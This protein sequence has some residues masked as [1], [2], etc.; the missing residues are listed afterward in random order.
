MVSA[1]PGQA[2]KTAGKRRIALLLTGL[3]DEYEWSVRAGVQSAVSERGATLMSVVGSAL[4]DPDPM[5]RARSFVFDLL[6]ANSVDALLLLGSTVGRYVGPAAMG[7]WLERYPLPACSIGPTDHVASVQVENAE[8]VAAAVRHLIVEH[9]YR[10]IA[11]V[12][13]P[14]KSA[15]A[16]A[17]YE[18]YRSVLRDNQLSEDPRLVLDGDFTV[19]GGVRAVRRLFDEHQVGAAEVDAIV[20]ANDN[21]AVG[22]IEELV[23][24]GVTVPDRVAVVGFDD[25]TSSRTMHPA[26]TTVRQPTEKLGREGVRSL[27]S[28]LEGEPSR[29]SPPLP[30]ELV[31]RRSCGCMPTEAPPA[32][33]GLPPELEQLARRTYAARKGGWDQSLL[34]SLLRDARGKTGDIER[35]LE[36]LLQR[37]LH[38]GV[39]L[40]PLQDLLTALR[41]QAL[42]STFHDPPLQAKIED[43]VHA[44]RVLV[45]RLQSHGAKE[46]A[47]SDFA[48]VGALSQAL[49]ARMFGTP[50]MVSSAL[51]E[52]L[53]GLGFDE[54][55]VSE[56]IPG[57]SPAQLQVAFGFHA[58]DL[59]P[60]AERYPGSLVVPPEFVRLR[61]QS[62]VLMPLTYGT[63]ALGIAILP[64]RPVDRRIYELLRPVLATT[65]KG[66]QLAR[67][68]TRG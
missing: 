12:R 64:A 55:V 35:T 59:Q 58:E 54:C 29:E 45:S 16:E 33:T 1:F 43:R 30:T 4:D 3:D 34:E 21:L 2:P 47:A 42:A 7:R 37:L 65:L 62:S 11:F 50:V 63:E 39:Q 23:H 28:L 51:V 18:A 20:C 8:G 41:S 32:S 26:L 17:R 14:Q 27:F 60:K 25:A 52:H 66:M 38:A 24:R 44:A 9:G 15:E 67:L 48:R 10:R 56:L 19:A 61:A 5:K 13:G 36:P 49:S 46:R 68:A 31:L 6:A 22:V 57:A 40:H 53:P